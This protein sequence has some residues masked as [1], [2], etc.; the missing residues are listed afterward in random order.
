M[1]PH[2]LNNFQIQNYYQN[3][4][5]FNDVYSKRNLPKIKDW[6]YVTNFG[7]FKSKGIHWKALS[8][9]G[10]NETHFDG[11]GV[12]HTPKEIKK[13]IGNKNIIENIYSI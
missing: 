12:E 1:L 2:P 6:I 9:N 3:K 10:N 5:Q 8:V 11:F 4:S 13:F 7:E